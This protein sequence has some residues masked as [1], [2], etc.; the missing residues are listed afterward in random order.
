MFS[1][2]RIKLWNIST[3]YQCNITLTGHTGFIIHVFELN[4][5]QII[6]FA[7]DNTIRLW[8]ESSSQCNDT[9]VGHTNNIVSV[10]PSNDG[11]LV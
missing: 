9:L 10:F 7:E 4:D 5:K 6:S 1:D 2:N 11:Q 3:P 8:N